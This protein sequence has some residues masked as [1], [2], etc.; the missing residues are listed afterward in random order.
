M[1]L[2]SDIGKNDGSYGGIRYFSCPPK[3]GL[4]VPMH[5]V[6]KD[7]QSH[8]R[9]K[10]RGVMGKSREGN[11]ASPATATPTAR[12]TQSPARRGNKE[13][14]VCACLYVH[15]HACVCVCV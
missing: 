12:E 13:T 14:Q 7:T 6:S 4:F 9:K 8:E 5:R 15:V 11:V 2:D 3:F 10:R 1:E